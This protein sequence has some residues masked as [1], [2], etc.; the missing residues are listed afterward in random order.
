MSKIGWPSFFSTLMRTKL[1]SWYMDPC[2]LEPSIKSTVKILGV[3]MNS[4]FKVDKQIISEIKSSFFQLRLLSKV[5]SFL[6]FNDVERVIQGFVSCPD[7]TVMLYMLV[8]V[9]PPSPECCGSSFNRNT[10]ASPLCWTPF[11]GSLYVFGLI[12][13]FY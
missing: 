10:Q 5:K 8:L 2:S 6:A 4:D 11:T 3:I 7:W 9:K 1:K 13:R 12:L